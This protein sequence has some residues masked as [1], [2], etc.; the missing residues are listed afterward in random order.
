MRIKETIAKGELFW[1]LS[2]FSQL[3]PNEMYGDQ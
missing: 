1:C 3:V 2:K